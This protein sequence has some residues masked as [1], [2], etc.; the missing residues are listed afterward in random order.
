MASAISSAVHTWILFLIIRVPPFKI[1]P[2]LHP[3]A[4]QTRQLLPSGS[5]NKKR[6]VYWK[7]GP[8]RLRFPHITQLRRRQILARTTLPGLLFFCIIPMAEYCIKNHTLFH[9]ILLDQY[10][11]IANNVN[12]QDYFNFVKLKAE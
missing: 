1:S 7:N 6:M 11:L 2:E 9:K 5:G 8:F 10:H 12:L 3:G 4:L